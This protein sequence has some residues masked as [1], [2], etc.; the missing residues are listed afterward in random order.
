MT[1]RNLLTWPSAVEKEPARYLSIY[2]PNCRSHFAED[3]SI[4]HNIILRLNLQ[5]NNSLQF[6]MN[7]IVLGISSKSVFLLYYSLQ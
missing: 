2:L 4:T 5:I 3:H 1:G 7:L 6:I